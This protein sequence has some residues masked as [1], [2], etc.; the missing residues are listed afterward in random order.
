[1]YSY[2]RIK[3]KPNDWGILANR[4]DTYRNLGNLSEA[5]N[6]YKNAKNIQSSPEI[7]MRLALIMHSLAVDLFNRKKYPQCL[8]QLN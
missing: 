1:M 8:E 2:S 3:Y 7:D 5:V 6:D 4:G